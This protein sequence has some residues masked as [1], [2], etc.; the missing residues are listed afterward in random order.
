LFAVVTLGVVFWLVNRANEETLRV[1]SSQRA[2][3]LAVE[4][5]AALATEMPATTVQQPSSTT[6]DTTATT[7]ASTPTTH[8]Q[9]GA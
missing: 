3:V 4:A 7:P 5:S 2:D 9:G 6:A 8:E 1:A